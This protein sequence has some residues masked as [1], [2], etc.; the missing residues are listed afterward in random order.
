MEVD[1]K[2]RVMTFLT[3]NMQIAQLD[4]LRSLQIT[5]G[6]R[7]LLQGNKAD[8]AVSRLHGYSEN[9]VRWQIWMALLVYI[10]LRFVAGKASGNRLS[11]ACLPSCAVLSGSAWSCSAFLIAVGQHMARQE[12]GQCLTM[13]SARFSPSPSR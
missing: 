6:Y 4:I 7:G 13:L 11:R 2:P 3:N 5:L 1:N 9:A 12:Y 8:A 10:L